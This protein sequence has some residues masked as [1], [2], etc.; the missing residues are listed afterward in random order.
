MMLALI[1]LDLQPVLFGE[2][3][4]MEV[5]TRS[6]GRDFPLSAKDTVLLIPFAFSALLAFGLSF[7]LLQSDGRPYLF[8]GCLVLCITCLAFVDRK[9]DIVLGTVLFIL[10]RITWSIA[11]NIL[12]SSK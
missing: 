11:I 1:W 3:K 4:H 2:N 8:S 9:K 5:K 12:H 7:T 10:L 6:R